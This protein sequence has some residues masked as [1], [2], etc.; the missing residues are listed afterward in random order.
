MTK[1]T[2]LIGLLIFAAG[3]GRLPSTA[4]NDQAG[5][6][7]AFIS[8]QA[9]LKSEDVDK[10]WAML[11]AKSQEAAEVIARELQEE[12]ADGDKTRKSD[13]EKTWGL[14]AAELTEGKAANLFKSKPFLARFSELPDSKIVKIAAR[15]DHGDVLFHEPS[16]DKEYL[17]LTREKGRWKV[18]VILSRLVRP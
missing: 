3:C 5:V 9:A 14:S 11:D 8:F 7:Q 18:T 12:M 17:S 10:M 15:G 6:Q 16:G 2:W 13:R 1:P 4:D